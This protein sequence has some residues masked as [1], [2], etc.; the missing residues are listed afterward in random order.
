MGFIWI[1]HHSIFKINFTGTLN[2]RKKLV[3]MYLNDVLHIFSILYFL[4]IVCNAIEY[5]NEYSIWTCVPNITYGCLMCHIQIEI[6][7]AFNIE[8]KLVS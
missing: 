7:K 5:V 3:K 1:V 4:K 8:K 6:M 2:S